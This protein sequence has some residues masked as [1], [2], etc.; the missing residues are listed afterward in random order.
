MTCAIPSGMR[1]QLM[2]LAILAV[3]PFSSSKDYPMTADPSVPA[4]AG[5]IHAQR[6]KENGNIKLDI[7]VRHLAKP[8]SLNPS[9]AHYIVWVR[10]QDGDAVK[11]GALGVD[12]DLNG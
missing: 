9:A 5:S 10:P 11:Q 6:D 2:L 1:V 3:W 8:S 4:A 12:K 7:K